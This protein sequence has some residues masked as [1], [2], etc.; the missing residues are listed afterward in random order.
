[1][2]TRKYT[3]DTPFD[4][5]FDMPMLGFALAGSPQP[6]VLDEVFQHF[7]HACFDAFPE[8]KTAKAREFIQLGN[9]PF[10]QKM[11]IRN[12]FWGLIHN[13]LLGIVLYKNNK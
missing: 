12:S 13:A 6:T 1:M 3:F 11:A 9:Q 7:Q 10:Q 2:G 5:P 4:T 8:G